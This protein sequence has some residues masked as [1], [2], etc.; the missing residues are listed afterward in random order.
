MAEPFSLT[1]E[2]FADLLDVLGAP[3]H[4]EISAERQ[5]LLRFGAS[6]VT[7]QHSEERLTVRTKLIRNGRAVWGTL[8]S[9]DHAKIAALRDRLEAVMA[10]L[11][12]SEEENV[13]LEPAAGRRAAT[14]FFAATANATAEDRVAQFT[15]AVQALPRG[16]TLGGSIVHSATQHAVGNSRGVFHAET[17]T[18][19]LA[20]FVGMLD[21]R[22]AY[23]RQ[24]NRDAAAL[25]L[26]GAL[27]S[28]TRGLTPMPTRALAPGAYRAV[29]APTA[30]I[31]LLATFAHIAL[32]G[33]AYSSGESTVAGRL[34]ARIANPTM[35][36]VDDA[37]D[38]AGLPAT[39]DCEGVPKRRVELIQNGV[40]TGVVHNAKSAHAVGSSSTGHAV[41][42]AWRFGAGP[43]PSHL[44]LAPGAHADDALLL[45][46]GD[47]LYIQRVDYVRVVHPKQA[48]VTGT[49]RDATRWIEKGRLAAR[50]PQ[51]RFS[52]R[53]DEL[54]SSVA[55]V[56][57]RRE[58][59][60]MVF[61]ESV[62]APALLVTQFPVD[63]VVQ[64]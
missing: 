22:S 32:T 35:N 30:V 19:A 47:G 46:C 2:Q 59:G 9:L 52:V 8:G 12:I 64:I 4:L 11:P 21:G 5:D 18:R 51:F 13:L 20:Q 48:L 26:A 62:V 60:E 1:R 57:N 42:P 7:Y 55:E 53:L 27:E 38:A 14:T 58:C 36:L 10:H 61:M 24:L 17:R 54:L 56:G 29:L 25:D 28:V 3:V 44:L 63:A 43:S 40:L 49:T 6:R 16:A 41:P 15:R 45:E 23:A 31:T 34:G 33:R 50:V 37:G 39:F